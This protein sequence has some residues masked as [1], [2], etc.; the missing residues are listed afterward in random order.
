LDVRPYRA[1]VSIAEKGSFSAAANSLHVSQPALSAQ[2]RELERRLGFALFT[3]TS[4]NVAL[5]REGELFLGNARR[6]I[7]ETEY[8]KQ[9]ARDIATKPLRIGAAHF[10]ALIPA[11]TGLLE[12][13][14]RGHPE[15]SLSISGRQHAQLFEDLHTGAIDAAITL[16]PQVSV[17]TSAVED[18]GA[19]ERLERFVVGS[20]HLSLR[21]PREHR[22]ADLAVPSDEALKGQCVCMI[23]RVHGILLTETVSRLLT[24]SGAERLR[25]PEGDAVSAIRYAA[26]RRLPVVDLG[27]FPIPADVQKESMV[28][29]EI[30][31]WNLAINL[32][33]VRS[34]LHRHS[35]LDCFWNAAQAYASRMAEQSDPSSR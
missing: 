3:R 15:V 14:M 24:A 18:H 21:V 17:A 30:E 12:A 10:S 35:A 1:F 4:R 34:R 29:R 2:I 16:E 32:V 9:A 33:V 27:W 11:R 13:F 6:I 22:L 26:L 8:I 28:V 31:N 25:V 19:E 7:L 5:T 23:S 20:R